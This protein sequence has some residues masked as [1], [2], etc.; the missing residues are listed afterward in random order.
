[1]RVVLEGGSG[2]GKST[3]AKALAVIT[4]IPVYRPF[5]GKDEHISPA[6]IRDMQNLGLS[7][8]N[9]QE[10]LYTADILSVVTSDVILDRSM[11]SAM[12]WNEVS[13]D[14]LMLAHRRAVLR[15]WAERIVASRAALVLVVCDEATRRERS[16]TRGGEWETAGIRKAIVDAVAV[17]PALEH[18]QVNTDSSTPE[19]IADALARRI[20]NGTRSKHIDEG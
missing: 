12:A 7:V 3:L 11:P 17:V 14:A 6:V 2:V 5:R 16:P 13:S 18:W 20:I 19:A 4:G 15:L 1:M 10:D 8:N 9:W